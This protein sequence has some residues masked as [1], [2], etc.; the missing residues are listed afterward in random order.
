MLPGVQQTYTAVLQSLYS[1]GTVENLLGMYCKGLSFLLWGSYAAYLL[2]SGKKENG[3]EIAALF[4]M[5]G[6]IFH[7]F[8]EGKSQYIYP[9]VFCLIPF[10]ARALASGLCKGFR[11]RALD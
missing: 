4:L 8:W 5:G 7:I 1:G 9:Y 11:R 2:T 6:F 10:C 3:W